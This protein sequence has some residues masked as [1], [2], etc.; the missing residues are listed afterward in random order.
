MKNSLRFIG[1]LG[2]ALILTTGFCAAQ[3]AGTTTKAKS[4]REDKSVKVVTGYP[5]ETVPGKAVAGY[6]LEAGPAQAV[7]VEGF[8][9]VV[10][11]LVSIQRKALLTFKGE[12]KISEVKIKMTDEYNFLKIMISSNFRAGQI[13]VELLDPKGEKRGEYNLKSNELIIT[14]D[15][16]TIQE[17]VSGN[18]Q[19]DFSNPLKGE[20]IIRAV[21]VAAEGTINVMIIQEFHPE[22]ERYKI[23]EGSPAKSLP[24]QKQKKDN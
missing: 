7:T 3:V 17:E 5:L 21:P 8:P 16:T 6:P 14:G 9:L 20:W 4:A 18:L 24:A 12:S 23:T 13:T 19:K 11:D 22:N 10:K 1:M 2:A 15:N